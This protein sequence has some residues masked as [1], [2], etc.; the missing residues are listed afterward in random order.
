MSKH[1]ADGQDSVYLV[2]EYAKHGL[3]QYLYDTLEKSERP[4]DIITT[5]LEDL[6]ASIE[7]IHDMDI[8]H[9]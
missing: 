7:T 3:E 5:R 4:W 6:A 9:R 8:V 2:I 1:S